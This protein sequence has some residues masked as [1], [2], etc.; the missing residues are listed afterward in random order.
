MITIIPAID[1]IAGECV[2]L[3]RGDYNQK[4]SY[5]KDPLEVALRYEECG[6]KRLHMV[7]LDGA[8]SKHPVNLHIVERVA[9]RT[10]LDIQMG[11]GI[12]STQALRDL[13]SAG[14]SRA[15]CGSVAVTNPELFEEWLAEFGAEKIILGADT[16]DG[17]V[18]IS[19]WLESSQM[20]VEQIIERFAGAGLTQVICTDIAQDGMLQ[21]PSTPLYIALQE[22]F[23]AIEITV[24]GGIS[25]ADD[26][27]S[28]DAHNLRSV[29]VG[30]AI[31]EGRISFEELKKLAEASC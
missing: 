7:D 15:I 16:K 29:I 14:A 28:L 13:F 12:K 3:T 21:G 6:L 23:P 30:K 17:K 27:L 9:S 8:K 31:Y 2:R 1:I 11:G 4:S 22:Q 18:A 5:Y 20:G 19:G 24:S 26:I 10:S 25:G